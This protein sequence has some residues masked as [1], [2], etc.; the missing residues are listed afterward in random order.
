MDGDMGGCSPHYMYDCPGKSP[1]SPTTTM[2]INENPPECEEDL[3]SSN[4]T[5]SS[6]PEQSGCFPANESTISATSVP[7]QTNTSL[8]DFILVKE[9]LFIIP[10]GNAT[11]YLVM[12]QDVAFPCSSAF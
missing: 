5:N 6:L 2:A 9:F 8:P 12:C 1:T 3:G 7:T 10:P 11:Q 4:Y